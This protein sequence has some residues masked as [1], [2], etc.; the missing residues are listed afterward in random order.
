MPL[1]YLVQIPVESVFFVPWIAASPAASRYVMD[2]SY[3]C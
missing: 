1:E 2:R 3:R